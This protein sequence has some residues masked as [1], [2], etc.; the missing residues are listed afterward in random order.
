MKI[1]QLRVLDGPNYWS[2]K[3]KQLV[4]IRLNQEEMT[5]VSTSKIGGFYERLQTLLPSLSTHGCTKGKPG[6]FLE[7]VQQ[8]T[9]VAHVVEH[10]ALALQQLAGM[11]TGFSRTRNTGEPG[12][13]NVIFSYIDKEA[14]KYAATAAV[15]LV[16]ALIKGEDYNLQY[17][18]EELQYIWRNQGFGPSTGSLVDEAVKRNIPFI[19]ID[20]SSIVQFGYGKNQKRIAATIA[21]TTSNIGVDIAGDKKLTK[22]ILDAELIPVPKGGI[23]YD[24]ENLQTIVNEIGYPLVIKPRDG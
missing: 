16:E 19:R 21:S 7:K 4:L 11:D 1:E 9:P 2:I 22:C 8:G 14:G 17:D 18:I 6:G 15:N 5:G 12:I 20:S 23:A 3:R 13:Y 24:E 10:V